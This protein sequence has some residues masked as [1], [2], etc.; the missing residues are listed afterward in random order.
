[1]RTRPFGRSGFE[2]SELALGTWG[3][4]GEAY[5][6]VYFKEVDRVIDRALELGITLFDTADVYGNGAM[7]KKLGERLAA[8]G[9][10]PATDGEAGEEKDPEKAEEKAEEKSEEPSG[11]DE[12]PPRPRIVTKIGTF[13]EETPPRKKFDA[14]SLRVAFDKS[15]ERIGRELDVVLL[16]NPSMRAMIEGEGCAF[17]G[18]RVEAGELEAW[19]VSAGDAEVAE[20]AVEAGAQ[21]VE[22]AY[23]VFHARD[24]HKLADL[25]A[26]SDTA[27]LA[28]SVLSYGLL[29]GHWQ[30]HRVFFDHD[31]R[32]KRW[33]KETLAHRVD[34][35][36]AV[37]SLLSEEVVTM[38]GA[39]LRFV[40]SNMLVSSAVLGPRSVIQLDQLA[41]EA[42]DGPPYL[43]EVALT[44]LPF[45]LE[46]MGIMS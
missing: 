21:V 14:E 36:A 29:A 22:L 34:Q 20:A 7:E 37:R 26:E 6:P 3:L 27:V 15:R 28:R 35:L 45:R 42:G 38:R 39:A 9:T 18:E 11:E 30:R 33:T 17:L 32:S 13:A 46:K 5:G 43:G 31:H 1:M 40:L 25:L 8:A 23:N 12:T 10:P 41:R 2:V 16:H 19:G 44:E 24:L 4:A